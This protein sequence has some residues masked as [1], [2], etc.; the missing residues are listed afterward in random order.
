MGGH[1]SSPNAR[2]LSREASFKVF[3]H[4]QLTFVSRSQVS[5]PWSPPR[6]LPVSTR[7]HHRPLMRLQRLVGRIRS[8]TSH[9]VCLFF[10]IS[11]ISVT[12][13]FLSAVPTT[14]PLWRGPASLVVPQEGRGH[15][16]SF[17]VHTSYSPEADVYN[18]SYYLYPY[19]RFCRL[20]LGTSYPVVVASGRL[21]VSQ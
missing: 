14:R 21:R 10:L 11:F 19:F 7:P 20:P 3:Y 6:L 4:Y 2:P 18:S 16:R 1:R 17:F 15:V 13:C 9:P 12:T 8:R 5:S